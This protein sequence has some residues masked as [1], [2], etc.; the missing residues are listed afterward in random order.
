MAFGI[1]NQTST[2]G[3]LDRL[4]ASTVGLELRPAVILATT[5]D[6]ASENGVTFLR[7]GL[8]L[9]LITASGKY[10]TFDDGHGDGSQ[11]SAGAVVLAENVQLDGST[12]ATASV[13]FKGTV[14]TDAVIVDQSTIATLTLADVQ[15]LS[16][17]TR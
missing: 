3:D 11:L 6:A 9:G 7:R 12:D 2:L 15:R 1:D 10:T 4:V 8:L 17:V 16:F 13:I 5:E 14:Y